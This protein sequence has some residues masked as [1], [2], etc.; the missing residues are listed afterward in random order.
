[1]V[2]DPTVMVSRKDVGVADLRQ[3]IDGL[4][5]APGSLSAGHNGLGT[6]GHLAMVR[7]EAAAG[8]KFNAIPFNGS[9]QQK[10]A[11]ASKTLDIAF[12]SAS[13]APDPENEAMVC[14]GRWPSSRRTR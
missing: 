1:M 8:V 5:A 12:L 11:L 13:E 10:A 7:L 9:A 6:N 3:A 2:S 14:A 4:K